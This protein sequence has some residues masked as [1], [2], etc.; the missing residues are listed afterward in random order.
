M[1]L[2]TSAIVAVVAALVGAGGAGAASQYLITNISQIKPSVRKQLRTPAHLV[3]SVQGEQGPRGAQGPVG[4]QGEQGPKGERGP[5]GLDGVPGPQGLQ[6]PPGLISTIDT[7]F[8]DIPAIPLAG[9]GAPN[10]ATSTAQCPPGE[11]AISG[12][13]NTVAIENPSSIEVI[14][15]HPTPTDQGWEV[16]ARGSLVQFQAVA[17]CAS[18]SAGSK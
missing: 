17:N 15:S 18:T 10:T 11:V 14:D 12:G 16:T 3:I 7:A 2:R 9:A 4:P 1:N 5:G 6:G 8:G 13:W